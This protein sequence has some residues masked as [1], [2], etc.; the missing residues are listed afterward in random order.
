MRVSLSCGNFPL[1]LFWAQSDSSVILETSL[2]KIEMQQRQANRYKSSAPTLY[3]WSSSEGLSR[4]GE[5]KTLDISTCG[6]FVLA[7]SCPPVGTPIKLEVWLPKL[8]NASPGVRLY[9]EGQVIRID[10]DIK[11]SGFAA[12]VNFQAE[13]SE[14]VENLDGCEN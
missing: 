12:T 4:G 14:E 6:V 2:R 9:G 7:V 3:R 8:H 13:G 5:G 1:D 10:R 11:R